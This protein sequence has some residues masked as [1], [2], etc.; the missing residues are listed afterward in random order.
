M[1]ITFKKNGGVILDGMN[2]TVIYDES[3][4]ELNVTEGAENLIRGLTKDQIGKSEFKN[5]VIINGEKNPYT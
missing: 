4:E 5:F 1:K 3:G 2:R